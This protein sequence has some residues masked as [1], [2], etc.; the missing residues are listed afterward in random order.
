[1]DHQVE[2]LVDLGFELVLVCGHYVAASCGD[3]WDE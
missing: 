2:D 1:V 3:K